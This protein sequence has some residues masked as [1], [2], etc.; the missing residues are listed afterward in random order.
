[1][2]LHGEVLVKVVATHMSACAGG[3]DC[4]HQPSGLQHP[5]VKSAQQRCCSTFPRPMITMHST[6]VGGLPYP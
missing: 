6:P 1:M 2:Q 4:P 3:N 5:A